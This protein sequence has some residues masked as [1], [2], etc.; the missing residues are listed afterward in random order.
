[1]VVKL[2][3]VLYTFSNINIKM[4]VCAMVGEQGQ[5][6]KHDRIVATRVDGEVKAWKKFEQTQTQLQEDAESA[7]LQ[8]LQALGLTGR[9]ICG[10]AY[11][12]ALLALSS[13]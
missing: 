12:S 5:A 8:R 6:A 1:M 11:T 7:E 10:A 9:W 13:R 4:H 2:M 3:H